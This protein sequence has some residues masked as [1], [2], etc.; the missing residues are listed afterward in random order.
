MGR[1][2]SP[3]T[4]ARRIAEAHAS[5]AP[6]V[7]ALDA[8]ILALT[9]IADDAAAAGSFGPAVQARSRAASLRVER[10]RLL[11]E[12]EVE[13]ATSPGERLHRLRRAAA[14]E[15]SWTAVASLLREEAEEAARVAA[16]V[17]PQADPL[18]TASPSEIV[19]VIEQALGQLPL[20]QLARLRTAIERAITSQAAEGQ[21]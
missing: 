6:R 10:D 11:A 2:P 8:E 12:V 9:K 3:A 4:K 13:L 17:Q 15:G 1:G 5:V 18:D 20:V 14:Q 21:R 19:E 7:A 16:Q